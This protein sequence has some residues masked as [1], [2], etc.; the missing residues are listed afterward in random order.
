[1]VA[2]RSLRRA[3]YGGVMFEKSE[4]MPVVESVFVK[5]LVAVSKMLGVWWVLLR[6][7]KRKF[8]KKCLNLSKRYQC[9]P[10]EAE[11]LYGLVVTL[12]RYPLIKDSK[13]SA[14]N[15]NFRELGQLK[16]LYSKCQDSIADQLNGIILAVFERIELINENSKKID[17]SSNDTNAQRRIGRQL[18]TDWCFVVYML[19]K[20]GKSQDKYVPLNLDKEDFNNNI[21]AQ[22]NVSVDENKLF[23]EC[24][25]SYGYSIE[26]FS[27]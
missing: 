20:I 25:V 26:R 24:L 4:D 6:I 10:K 14:T 27:E 21:R 17:F 1:L 8:F 22:L 3:V 11:M 9:S 13:I 7:N 18:T 19:S 23:Q 5:L 12:H 15:P 2:R 16:L